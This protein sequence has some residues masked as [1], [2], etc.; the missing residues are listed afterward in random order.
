M[1]TGAGSDAASLSTMSLQRAAEGAAT[2]SSGSDLSSTVDAAVSSGGRPLDR[3][4][5]TQMEGA[6]DADFGNVRIH[7]GRAA[8]TSARALQAAAYTQ[9][10]DIV[11]GQGN[12][13]P[14]TG[15]GRHL[16]AHELAHVVQQRAGRVA[17]TDT[18]RGVAVSDPGDRF[19]RAAEETARVVTRKISRAP[20]ASAETML[21][22]QAT[23]G[24]AAVARWRAAASD[25]PVRA[26]VVQR[27]GGHPCAGNCDHSED[28]HET[29]EGIAA[30]SPSV[31]RSTAGTPAIQRAACPATPTRLG[32]LPLDAASDCADPGRSVSGERI[33]FCTDSDVMTDVGEAL[34]TALVPLL[35]TMETVD[36]HGFA[37]PEGPAGRE[38]VYNMNLSCRRAQ[39]VAARLIAS[40]VPASRIS[41]F[42]HGGGTEFGSSRPD[43][44]VVV[45]PISGGGRSQGPITT[46]FRVASVSY[47]ACAGCNPF[48]DDGSLALSPPA[49][50]PAV[51]SGYRM[52]HWIEAEVA[53]RD[54]THIESG[55]ARVVD[56]GHSVGISGYCGTTAPGHILMAAGPGS[57]AGITD[58]VHGEGLQ[59][60]SEL[61]SQVNVSVPPTLPDAPC[62]PLGTSPMIPPIRSRFR[63]RVFADGTKE[64]G[65]VSASTMPLH[66][67][68]DDGQLKM[69]GGMPVRAAVDFPAWATST[70]VSLLQ[71]ETGLKA[72]RRKC[73]T[74]SG[75]RGLV[76]CPVTCVGGRTDLAPGPGMDVGQAFIAC[77]GVAAGLAMG[78][79][80]TAC[81]AAGAVCTLPTL[82]ANP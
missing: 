56:S 5:R 2:L 53:T 25:V 66:Y 43:N 72:L 21:G 50:E 33:F 51:G 82:P 14:A 80:P 42:K 12:Y 48:T 59:W 52:K 49:T 57:P 69:F 31:S 77:M 27:C 41:V 47:L 67:L 79:C 26:A 71:A 37:S 10:S 78:S 38:T 65:F 23:A 6:F 75:A 17:A 13:A 60:E 61:T 74:R 16:L 44:R 36:L 76:G 15:N 40:G 30:T 4:V 45:I 1:P 29:T 39:S 9:G 54:R 58:P 81:A 64:S 28:A 73:C 8:A 32:D 34:L 55:S 20:A 62:G 22:L 7:T 19:E 70:G 24:N 35:M 46:R 63:L 68:Y 11:F 18:G 3:S